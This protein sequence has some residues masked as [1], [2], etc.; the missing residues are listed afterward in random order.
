MTSSTRRAPQSGD[1]VSRATAEVPVIVGRLRP[2]PR[3]IALAGLILAVLVTAGLGCAGDDDDSS[4][5]STS[6]DDG[7]GDDVTTTSRPA[8][9]PT[10]AVFPTPQ[11]IRWLGPDVGVPSTVA[12]VAGDGIDAATR[13]QLDDVLQAA[14]ART[15]SESTGADEADAELVVHA[16]LLGDAPTRKALEAARVEAP[17]GVPAEG[18][19]L[20]VAAGRDGGPSTIVVG[21]GDPAGIA[22]GV[23]TLRQVSR[24]GSVAGVSVVDHPTMPRRGVVEGFYGSPWTQAERLD[25]IAFYGQ[26][27]LNTY[28]YA[29]KADPFHRDRWREPYPAADLAG[30]HE[31]IE[32][33]A[34]NHVR[35]TFAVSPGKSICYTDTADVAALINKLDALYQQGVRDF[36]IALDDI[37]Y[38]QWNCPADQAHFGTNTGASAARAQVRLLNGLEGGFGMSHEGTRPFILVP[39]EYRNTDDSPYRQVI[40][41]QLDPAIE[42]MWTGDIVVPAEITA[43]QAKAAGA[44]FGRGVFVWDNFPVNDFPRTAGRLLLGPYARRDPGLGTEIDGIVSNPMNQA[45]ASKVAILGVA[46]FTWNSPAYD[47]ARAHREAASRLAANGEGDVAATAEALLAF[48]DLSNF[49]PTSARSEATISQ[50]QAPALAEKIAAFDAAWGAGDRAGAIDGL[51]PY[52]SLLAAAP[53]RIRT[54]V[55]DQA[56]VADCMPWLDALTRWGRAFVATLDGLQAQLD[57]DAGTAQDRFAAAQSDVTQARAI[58]TIP[59][60]TLPQGPVLLG[61]GVL[62]T[63]IAK[64]T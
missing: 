26:M 8:D 31:V 32:A 33:A 42:V 12:L 24:D 27:K 1:P 14:G 47:P 40:R 58:H 61:D 57:G 4:S 38:D 59:D 48:F 30:L 36:A 34:A 35:F 6:S 45:A 15:V 20:A 18:Y 19:V 44:V 64:H 21:G 60:E 13:Q 49:T 11:Q 22:Y 56:F 51:R 25:Q 63:F 7:R 55:G 53:E 41:D 23:D 2:I 29:P 5:S 3:R 10:P 43:A 9:A 28:I 37:A 17:E 52:A 62:D 46:D 39:T 50:P 16:G 54:G